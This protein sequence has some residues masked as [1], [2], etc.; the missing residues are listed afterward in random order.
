VFIEDALIVG[1]GVGLA[2]RGVGLGGQHTGAVTEKAAKHMK[3]KVR[4]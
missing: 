1:R 2:D 3:P 4:K